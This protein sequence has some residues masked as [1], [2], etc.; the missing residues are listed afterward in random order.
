M[1]GFRTSLLYVPPSVP[2][3][4]RQKTILH[5]TSTPPP[6]GGVGLAFE[7][8]GDAHR[9]LRGVNFEFWSHLGCSGKKRHYI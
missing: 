7:K 6:Q 9:L 4:V 1:F 2:L 8:G 3:Y 5:E